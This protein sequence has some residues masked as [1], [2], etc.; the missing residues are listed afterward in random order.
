MNKQLGSLADTLRRDPKRSVVLGVLIVVLTALAFRYLGSAPSPAAADGGAEDRPD[1]RSLP[2]A[3]DIG[4][5][6]QLVSAWSNQPV[7]HVSRNLF[8]SRLTQPS[9]SQVT[10][11]KAAADSEED[12]L[13]WR[14]LERALASRADREQYRRSLGEAVL[15]DAGSLVVTSIVIAPESSALIGEKLVGV[16][17]TIPGGER[18]SFTVIAIEPARVILARDGHRVSLVLGKPGALLETSE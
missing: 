2:V 4:R 16:G 10:A 7:P 1:D 5:S 15:R 11:P 12:G 3:P 6:A 8:A 18:G 13:F 14:Q 9:P 17:G